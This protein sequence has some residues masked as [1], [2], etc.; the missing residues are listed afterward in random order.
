MEEA[1]TLFDAAIVNEDGVIENVLV[2]DN[3]DTMRE[4]GAYHLAPGQGIGDIYVT[5]EEY[6]T[7]RQK[8][9]LHNLVKGG[10]MEV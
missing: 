6:E 8:D 7:Q 10:I 2:F 4:F 5:P 3:E 9:E 1:N